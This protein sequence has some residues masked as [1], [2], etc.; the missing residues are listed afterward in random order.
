MS[1]KKLASHLKKTKRNLPLEQQ[2]YEAGGAY[3]R[4]IYDTALKKLLGPL[5]IKVSDYLIKKGIKG[6]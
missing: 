1:S 5:G 3:V 2:S 6:N 4:H